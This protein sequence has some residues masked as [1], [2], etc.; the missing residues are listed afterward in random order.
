MQYIAIKQ[1]EKNGKPIFLVNAISLKNKN[2]TVVQKIPHPLGSDVLSFDNLEDA[3]TAITLAGFSYILPSGEKG[4]AKPKPVKINPN[5]IDYETLTYNAIAE[6]VNST[7]TNI[8]AAATL[9]IS[10]FPREETFDV[11]FNKIGEDNDTVRKN[12]IAGICRYPS[13]LQNRIIEALNSSNWVV[14]NSAITCIQTLAENDYSAIEN[15]ILPLTMVC[16]DD[17]TIVQANALSTIAKT[18][19][20]YKQNKKN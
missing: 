17:N 13:I 7:N 8:A 11:L 19:A 6:K 2:K 10:E 5:S 1:E 12:A 18:Y 15:F 9:A 16:D 14:R 4:H 3:K 20:K